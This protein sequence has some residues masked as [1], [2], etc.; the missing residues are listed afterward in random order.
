ML[1]NTCK[2]F[3]HKCASCGMFN[4]SNISIFNIHNCDDYEISCTCGNKSAAIRSKRNLA[5]II[6]ISCIDCATEHAYS[7]NVKALTNREL[8]ECKCPRTKECI[9][10]LGEDNEVRDR[11]DRLEEELD[12]LITRYGYESYFKNTQVMLQTLNKIH[13]IAEEGRLLCECGS[14]DVELILLSD[15]IYLKCRKCPGLRKIYAGSNNDL[16]SILKAENILLS[17]KMLP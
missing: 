1:L 10:L 2:T 3:V 17:T 13:D 5:G 7:F 4:F 11:I 12:N 6:Y 14:S 15:M 9:G 16:K 8:V